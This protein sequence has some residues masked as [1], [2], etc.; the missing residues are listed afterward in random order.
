MDTPDFGIIRMQLKR[1]FPS[2]K[3]EIDDL[4]NLLYDDVLDGTKLEEAISSLEY[5]LKITLRRNGI[6]FTPDQLSKILN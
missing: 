1:E 3:R 5:D 6:N 2:I 4:I